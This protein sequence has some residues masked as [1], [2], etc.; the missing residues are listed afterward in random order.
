[1]FFRGEKG[2]LPPPDIPENVRQFIFA[3]IDS[4]EQLEVLFLL[5]AEPG[6]SYTA[7]QISGQ[8]RSSEASV[9]GRLASLANAGLIDGDPVNG[10]RYA[11][12]NK[13]IFAL[14]DQLSESYRILRHRVLELI[15]SPMKRARS[16]AD[17]FVVSKPG[18]KNEDENG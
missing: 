13:E 17:A 15:F 16:F 8:L 4:V 14:V 12:K 7:S 2:T 1:L 18:G 11:P 6:Q 9:S 3:Y 5:R 10:F